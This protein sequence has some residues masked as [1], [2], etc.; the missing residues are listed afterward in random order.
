MGGGRNSGDVVAWPTAEVS[1]MDPGF[2]T[3]IVTW[4]QDADA[5]RKQAILEQMEKDSTA[6]GLAEIYAVQAVIRPPDTRRYLIQQLEIHE[7][8]L[9]GGIGQ[10]RMAAWPAAY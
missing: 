7:M 8:R 2:A 1:F 3:E 5:A 9:S 6:F 4:G 10:H